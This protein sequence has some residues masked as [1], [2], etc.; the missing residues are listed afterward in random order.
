MQKPALKTPLI[1]PSD[2][3]SL[4]PRHMHR[5]TLS[6]TSDELLQSLKSSSPKTF[7]KSGLI[8]PDMVKAQLSKK[9]ILCL[10]YQDSISS[11]SSN[12]DEESN[13][14]K[15]IEQ[16]KALSPLTYQDRQ[17]PPT[18]AKKPSEKV[19]FNTSTTALTSSE[20]NNMDRVLNSLEL[21]FLP[22][23]E[24][25]P[26]RKTLESLM[27][28]CQE[29]SF[30]MALDEKLRLKGVYYLENATGYFHRIMADDDSPIVI[31]PRRV[32]EFLVYEVNQK[33]FLRTS[34]NRFE[35]FVYY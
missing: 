28:K 5:R 26:S 18:K 20:E 8:T 17:H 4:K 30:A 21:V 3:Q 6:K 34:I 16:R 7:K 14:L 2:L 33:K 10:N 35:A 32:K 1:A 12:S 25:L 9:G 13:I 31:P 23:D 24:H 19:S 22:G 27:Q 29:P 11:N 15:I